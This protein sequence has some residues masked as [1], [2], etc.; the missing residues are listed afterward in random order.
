MKGHTI[1]GTAPIDEIAADIL[2]P[3]GEIVIATD[4]AEESLLPL[5]KD[6]IGLVVRGEGVADARVIEA[7]KDLR[8]I[9]RS[10]A[11]YNNVDIASAT[12]RKI[13]VVYTPGLNARALAE[14]AI[15]LM[16]TLCKKVFYWDRQLKSGNWQSRFQSKPGDL[17]GAT[18][19]IIGFGS[20][21][22]KLAELIRPF[23]MR[24]LAYDPYVSPERVEQLDAKLA[25]LNELLG[26]SDFICIHAAL[27]DE[28]RGLINRE[29]LAMVKPR[30][31]LINLARGGLVES[32]DALYEAMM[33]GTLGGVGLDVFEPEPPEVTHP[34]FR[35]GNCVTAPHA[36]GMT[37]R[38]MSR[39]FQSM[40]TDMAKVLK[41]ERPQFVVNPEVFE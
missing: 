37:V 34:I 17:D 28:T 2:R 16:L 24:V 19:G 3:F 29:R 32:L 11:G 15:T 27:T 6:A 4:H 31:Y 21:G 13:P 39:I 33:D 9:G 1:V 40:A 14:A 20:I 8:V 35:L 12:S 38:A 36:L 22:Q 26:E 7:A 5:L 41:G 30:A 23:N 25:G 10:G 18:L